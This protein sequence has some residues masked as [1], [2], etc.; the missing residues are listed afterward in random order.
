MQARGGLEVGGGGEALLMLVL[1]LVLVL[2]PLLFA[3][4]DLAVL[5]VELDG[6]RR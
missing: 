1:V 6:A 3:E 4:G 5:R 2:M